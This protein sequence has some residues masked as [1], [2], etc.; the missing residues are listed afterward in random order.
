LS[1]RWGYSNIRDFLQDQAYSSDI[2]GNIRNTLGHYIDL[3]LPAHYGILALWV[4]ATYFAQLFAAFPFVFLF[5]PKES[6]KS[7]L[8]T[9]LSWIAFNGNKVK[10]ITD[11]ALGYFADAMRGSILI[12]QA[13]TLKPE[14]V[15][16]LADSYKK[17]GGKRMIFGSNNSKRGFQ[18]FST[19]GAKGFGATRALD[20]DLTDR[21]ALIKMIKTIKK[22]PMINAD[23]P[24]W[25]NLRDACYRFLFMKHA[26][27]KAAYDA[28]PA[29]GTRQGELWH[30]LEAVARVL[31]LPDC[32]LAVI[33]QAFFEC[34]TKSKTNI[35]APVSALFHVLQER[36]SIEPGAFVMTAADIQAQMGSLLSK[37]EIQSNQWIGQKL[38]LFSLVDEANK[39]TRTRSK[40]MHYNFYPDQIIDILKRYI[41]D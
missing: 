37:S 25:L 5:G 26:D 14:L 17:S 23:N 9:I 11:A 10:H 31:Q 32:E 40:I 19:Y 38:S 1:D 30:P 27:I 3:R 8:L 6:G 28:I 13:E 20:A 16:T 18:E 15:G 36:A 21:C 2:Y 4:I 41:D 24:V 22:M 12:D 35:S 33:K 34:T 39:K 29:T 7:N